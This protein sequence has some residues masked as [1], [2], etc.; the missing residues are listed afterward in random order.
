M[1]DIFIGV[2]CLWNESSNRRRLPMP[3]VSCAPVSNI[4]NHVGIFFAAATP[5][6]FNLAC[7]WRTY[8]YRCA[9]LAR[10]R[11]ISRQPVLFWLVMKTKFLRRTGAPIPSHL[12]VSSCCLYR[13]C[14]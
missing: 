12:A 5:D 7:A 3:V 2:R 10:P 8:E 13:R 4:I 14:S 11:H 6:I 1:R 9:G